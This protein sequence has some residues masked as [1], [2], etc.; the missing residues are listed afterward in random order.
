MLSSAWKNAARTAEKVRQTIREGDSF[1]DRQ[2]RT[3]FRK[4]FDFGQEWKG[5][6]Y[7]YKELTVF[8]AS[9]GEDWVVVTVITRYH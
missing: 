6:Y 7:E 4:T 2:G 3:G 9:K 8:A 5:T 1:V